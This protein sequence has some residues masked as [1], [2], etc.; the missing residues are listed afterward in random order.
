M[1]QTC[2]C[3]GFPGE[4]GL[5]NA[6]LRVV[7][8]LAVDEGRRDVSGGVAGVAKALVQRSA[9]MLGVSRKKETASKGG[10]ARV[11]SEGTLFVCLIFYLAC[12]SCALKSPRR[13]CVSEYVFLRAFFSVL[14]PAPSC[15]ALRAMCL[16][17]PRAPN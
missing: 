5:L 9:S 17:P 4:K 8:G 7:A 3:L 16:S 12:H 10:Y 1:G 11:T 13:D 14:G 6:R 15:V 2:V